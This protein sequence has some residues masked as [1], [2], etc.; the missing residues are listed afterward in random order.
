MVFWNSN[1]VG[2]V[3]SVTGEESQNSHLLL[4]DV[5]ISSW[6]ILKNKVTACKGQLSTECILDPVLQQQT[7]FH[8][9][10]GRAYKVYHHHNIQ[11]KVTCAKVGKISLLHYSCCF[12]LIRE[13]NAESYKQEECEIK[14]CTV[15]IWNLNTLNTSH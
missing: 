1:G 11:Q 13:K 5:N 12:F 8:W 10:L 14:S 4:V 7:C 6:Y 2:I 9:S 15:I 3:S